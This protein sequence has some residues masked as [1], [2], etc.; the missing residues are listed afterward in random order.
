[1]QLLAA[2]IKIADKDL[3]AEGVYEKNE[4][5]R[6]LDSICQEQLIDLCIDPFLQLNVEGDIAP[7]FERYPE[8]VTLFLVGDKPKIVQAAFFM[9][10]ELQH[11]I[12]ARPDILPQIGL[13]CTAFNELFIEHLNSIIARLCKKHQVTN[14]QGLRNQSVNPGKRRED[15]AQMAGTF[16]CEDGEGGARAEHDSEIFKL[17][18]RFL[19]GGTQYAQVERL[20]EQWLKPLMRE[21]AEVSVSSGE[22]QIFRGHRPLQMQARRMDDRHDAINKYYASQTKTAQR[23]T[24]VP[25][26]SAP[27]PDDEFTYHLNVSSKDELWKVIEAKRESGWDDNRCK[28]SHNKPLY[29]HALALAFGCEA[30]DG[31]SVVVSNSDALQAFKHFCDNAVP[32]LIYKEPTERWAPGVGQRVVKPPKLTIRQALASAPS[33][34]EA[35][36]LFG[37]LAWDHKASPFK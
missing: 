21:Y 31:G 30:D 28:K 10:A 12:V 25:A 29:I 37:T 8:M 15:R 2:T 27:V 7:F 23:D 9:L 18:R 19:E 26:V 3:R 24:P 6:M 17:S 34:A 20:A 4:L 35:I 11:L 16:K 22:N 36:R 32:R 33:E 13:H 5:M 14:F 1:M